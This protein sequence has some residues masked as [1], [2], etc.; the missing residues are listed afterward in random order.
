MLAVLRTAVEITILRPDGTYDTILLSSAAAEIVGDVLAKLAVS[1]EV[2]LLGGEDEVSPEDAAAILGISRPLVRRRMD[3]G[4][5]PFRRVGAHRR[6]RL[7]DVLDLKR[8]GS[9]DQGSTRSAEGGYGG[10]GGAWPLKT[11]CG[12]YRSSSMTP[13]SF[14]PFIFGICL[15]NSR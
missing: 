9:A 12:R 1:D 4:V 14:T 8:A 15:S 13:I 7:A 3:A 11:T 6:L 2:I 10:I 5:L